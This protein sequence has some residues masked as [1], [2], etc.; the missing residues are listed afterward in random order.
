M[1]C[2]SKADY[3]LHLPF[4]NTDLNCSTDFLSVAWYPCFFADRHVLA[5]RALK[6]MLRTLHDQEATCRASFFCSL[7][8]SSDTNAIVENVTLIIPKTNYQKGLTI[9]NSPHRPRQHQTSPW[10]LGR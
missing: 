6:E 10:F 3:F 5:C 8:A 1:R 7:A 4:E 9:N 2:I